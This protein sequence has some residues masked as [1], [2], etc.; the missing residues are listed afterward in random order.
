MD[1]YSRTEI[2]IGSEKLEKL[3]IGRWKYSVKW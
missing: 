2:L 1:M 3:K